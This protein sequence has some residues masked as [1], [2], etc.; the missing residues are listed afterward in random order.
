M[1]ASTYTSMA[2]LNALFGKASAFGA[3]ASAPALNLALSTTDP[4]VD[5]LT[6]P[7]GNGYARVATS[8]S[9]WVAATD[10][11]PSLV[12]NAGDIAFPQATGAWGTLGW[13]A[14]V[15]AS[16]NVI[17]SGAMVSPSTGDSLTKSPTEGDTP[18]VAAGSA[19]YSMT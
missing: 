6:E 19:I 9:D 2:L 15:D 10:A 11:D 17:L 12:T 14:L 3:L 13:T 7:S 1:S 4:E 8:A 16:D 18:T 5:G